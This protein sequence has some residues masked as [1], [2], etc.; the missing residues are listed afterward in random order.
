LICSRLPRSTSVG[1]A[2]E[3]AAAS[4][5]AA[6]AAEAAV[7]AAAEASSVAA[8]AACSAISA[9][10]AGG[11]GKEEENEEQRSAVIKLNGNIAESIS[12]GE[13]ANSVV[14]HVA[15]KENT[16]KDIYNNLKARMVKWL[17]N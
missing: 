6:A 7:G 12:G 8:A 16:Q 17:H 4:S 14:A 2:A 15:A 13:H 9:A 3:A 10:A 11:G 1:A 5:A